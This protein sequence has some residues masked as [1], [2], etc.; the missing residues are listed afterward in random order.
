MGKKDSIFGDLGID[1]GFDFKGFNVTD[2][3]DDKKKKRKPIP[4]GMQKELLVGC[5]GK[6]KKCKTSLKG[7][8]PDI[9]HK[10]LDP[11]DNRKANLIVLCPNCHR[12]AHHKDGKAVKSTGSKPGKPKTEGMVTVTT[13]LGG[14]ERI[15]KKDA[16]RVKNLFTGKMEWQRKLL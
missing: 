10:N 2:K 13:I 12:K 11:S 6:C 7:L 8:K 1:L 15:P 3:Y 4:M 14:K 16:V 9:H 5:K